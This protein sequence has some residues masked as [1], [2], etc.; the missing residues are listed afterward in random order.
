[1]VELEPRELAQ[2]THHSEILLSVYDEN[3]QP[4]N[5][6][7]FITAAEALNMMRV[8]NHQ[9]IETTLRWLNAYPELEGP[10]G[11]VAINISGQTIGDADFVS[12]VSHRLERW[13]IPP[14]RVGFELTETAAI[15]DIERA[16]VNLAQ[17]KTLGC[18]LY[19]SPSPLELGWVDLQASGADSRRGRA[20]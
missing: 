2:R 10:L 6:G 1:L 5:L 20:K 19:L 14:E 16:A 9:V 4:L 8:L 11:S 13:A 7:D 17:M 15:A 3:L 18:L 12:W